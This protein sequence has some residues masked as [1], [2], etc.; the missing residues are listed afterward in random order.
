MHETLLPRFKRCEEETRSLALA[1][2]GK[3]VSPGPSG[4]PTRG[5]N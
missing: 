2:E 5:K 4:A 1:L 3:F